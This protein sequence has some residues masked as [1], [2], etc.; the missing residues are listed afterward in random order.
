MSKYCAFQLSVLVRVTVLSNSTAAAIPET[1]PATSAA[2]V[3]RESPVEPDNPKRRS[4][5]KSASS[6]PS[7]SGQQSATRP[8]TDTQSRMQTGDPLEVGSAESTTLPGASSASTRRRIA[9]KS[10]PVA[11][12][13][14]EAVDGHREKMRIVS[15][16]QVELDNIMELSITGHVL[17]WARVSILWETVAEQCRWMEPEESKSL[18]SRQSLA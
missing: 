17:K 4:L 3:L 10:E 9:V 18:D 13:T 2:R 11:V 6:T 15:L 16:E 14:Q 1:E 5:M 12:T 7:G 8:V